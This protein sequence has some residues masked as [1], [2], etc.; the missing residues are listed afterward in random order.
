MARALITAAIA[1][2]ILGRSGC[3]SIE[4]GMLVNRCGLWQ[5]FTGEPMTIALGEIHERVV[6]RYIER[7]VQS[8]LPVATSPNIG[9]TTGTCSNIS[10]IVTSSGTSL[11]LSNATSG[12]ITFGPSSGT[13][14]NIIFGGASSGTSAAICHVQQ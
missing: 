12:N 2:L 1:L 3:L 9:T 6:E 7:S 4:D 10:E 13:S 14:G 8:S 11:T 5:R